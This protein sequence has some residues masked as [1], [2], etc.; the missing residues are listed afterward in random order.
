MSNALEML[1]FLQDKYVVVPFVHVNHNF[2]RVIICDY[3]CFRKCFSRDLNSKTV[4]FQVL[5]VAL[6]LILDTNLFQKLEDD[7]SR[8]G[9][10]L[11]GAEIVVQIFQTV[12][13]LITSFHVHPQIVRQL[14]AYLFFF[15]NASLFNT[16]MDRGAGG[17]FY[18]WAKGAQIR[19]NL[20]MLEG[21]AT[22]VGLQEEAA[23]YLR[24][25][26]SAADVLAIP[27]VQLLQV[28]RD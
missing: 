17:K 2:F 24:R 26:S 23:D 22:D 11:E 19:G 16:L 28:T 6:P 12:Y 21:W 27:K 4:C 3:S 25:L 20:D 10:E 13:D 8:D 7:D 5:Y 15:T 14:F 1:H 18:R 9:D